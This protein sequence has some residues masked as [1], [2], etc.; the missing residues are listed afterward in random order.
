M[1]HIL[2]SLEPVAT[3]IL[4]AG[5]LVGVWEFAEI[6]LARHWPIGCA[7]VSAIG[8]PVA[9]GF[10][11]AAGGLPVAW[12]VWGV[13]LVAPWLWLPAAWG[14]VASAATV[15]SWTAVTAYALGHAEKSW[16]GAALLAGLAAVVLFAGRRGSFV[17]LRYLVGY[18]LLAAV[19]LGLAGL[20]HDTARDMVRTAVS[21]LL[22]GLYGIGRGI[23]SSAFEDTKRR[24]REDALTG[25]LTRHGLEWWLA[26][27]AEGMRQEGLILACDLDDFKW[28]NDTYGHALGD[29]VLRE[30][31][32]RLRATLRDKDALVR[33]AGDEFTVW[34]PGV[35]A[36][37]GS[38]VADRVHQAVTQE[39]FEAEGV[40]VALRLSVGWAAGPLTAETADAA[41]QALLLAKRGGKNRVA[42]SD[43]R[44]PDGGGERMRAAWWLEPAAAALWR[45]RSGACVLVD[46]NGRIVTCNP[47][48]E[49]L[50]GRSAAELIGQKPGMNSAG[51]TPPVLYAK[52]WD[53][54]A[55]GQ[56]VHVLLLNRRP[57]GRRWWAY[58]EISPLELRGDN[59]GYWAA[60][61]DPLARRT[62]G[63]AEVDGLEAFRVTP[64]FQPVVDVA[65][66][67]VIGYEALA[68]L[69]A[70]REVVAPEEFFRVAEAIGA[71]GAADRLCLEAVAAA[72]RASA[73]W[74]RDRRLALNV[75][76]PTLANATWFKGFLAG[77]PVPNRLVIL[78]ISEAD[79]GPAG[80]MGWRRL[81][82]V[83][84]RVGFAIDDWGSGWHDINRLADL[85]PV[86]TKV[87]R[88]WLLAAERSEP[89]RALLRHLSGWAAE[90]GT[91]LVAEGVETKQQAALVQELGIAA[92]QGYY[93]GRPTP[94]VPG[95]AIVGRVVP[96]GA[97]D[98]TQNSCD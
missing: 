40:S 46:T 13:A 31:A 36:G 21:G 35:P 53:R 85:S 55:H 7:I 32:R 41:D 29:A 73:S 65:T 19:A 67:S 75:R 80:P 74:P 87:D 86:W 76:I 78:E 83:Y 22:I 68:R 6:V 17:R 34:M 9:L 77:L 27:V 2:G 18:G 30:V 14:V 25:A 15:A 64:V 82:R 96:R 49:R 84:G 69:H 61:R 47:E 57:T 20:N 8:A 33:P 56:T 89:A 60:V 91:V 98:G 93:W 45:H 58:E 5:L 37:E 4:A 59:V 66:G 3:G 52:L 50:T 92:G 10:V 90:V 24:A 63:A 81:R 26:A 70:G 79:L 97:Q 48:Y 44:P 38:V 43:D 12:G 94:S 72:L 1:G 54:I 23:R 16:V 51:V 95:E 42:A 71:L 62:L 11:Q 88:S 28:L 39:A